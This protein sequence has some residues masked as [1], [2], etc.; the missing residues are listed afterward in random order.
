MGKLRKLIS[1]AVVGL[2]FLSSQAQAIPVG[3]E[4]VLLAD[5]SGSLDTTDFNLQRDGYEAAFRD[6]DVISAIES[7]GGIAVTLVYWSTSQ[8][9]AVNWTHITDATSAN[10]FA[11]AIAAAGRPFTGST[12]MA[13]AIDYAT[14]LF[15]NNFE[16]TD[17]VIDVSGDGSDSNC[18]N[19]DTCAAT[20]AARDAAL[21]A[22]IDRINALWIEDEAQPS[23]RRYFCL[24]P[25]CYVNPLTFGANSVIGGPGSFQN[26]VS[27]FDGFREGIA[28]KIAAEV[29]R[30]PEPATI[31][32]MGLGLAGLGFSRKKK[33]S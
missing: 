1:A 9:V 30:V 23:S 17:L 29:R 32:L 5:V 18:G 22:G 13:E 11:D 4:L 12:Y 28:N 15:D 27:D 21:A 19:T 8:S 16:G 20:Q 25:T 31:A 14:D 26:V 24:D 10:A 6:S 7:A 33:L 2:L 3:T